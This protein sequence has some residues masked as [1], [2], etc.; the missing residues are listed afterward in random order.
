MPKICYA[1]ILEN[2]NSIDH[3]KNYYP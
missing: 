2:P 3:K 1:G